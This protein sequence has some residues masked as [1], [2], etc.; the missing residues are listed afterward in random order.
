MIGFEE[1]SAGFILMGMGTGG[2]QKAK[3]VYS[4][5]A[6]GFSKFTEWGRRSNVM[7]YPVDMGFTY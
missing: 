5:Q 4:Y 3:A 7:Y 1:I 2:S 6:T